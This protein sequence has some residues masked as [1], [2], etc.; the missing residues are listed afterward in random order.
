MQCLDDHAG[1]MATSHTFDQNA[2]VWKAQVVKEMTKEEIAL[3]QK[4]SREMVEANPKLM[5]D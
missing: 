4:L 1:A 2:L 5:G 3:A